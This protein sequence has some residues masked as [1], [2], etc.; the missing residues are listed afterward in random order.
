MRCAT[1]EERRAGTGRCGGDGAY[2]VVDHLEELWVRATAL[3]ND[4]E[5]LGQGGLAGRAGAVAE[6]ADGLIRV[7]TELEEAVGP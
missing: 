1:W 4:M 6:S 5:A 2:A 3:R 7:V